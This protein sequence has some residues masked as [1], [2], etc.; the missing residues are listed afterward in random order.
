MGILG[1]IFGWKKKED[2]T[3]AEAKVEPATLE[4]QK[5]V[6]KI[7]GDKELLPHADKGY[8]VLVYGGDFN[9]KEVFPVSKPAKNREVLFN[10]KTYPVVTVDRLVL[11]TY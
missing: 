4:Y 9:G 10:G 11:G 1:N 7:E 5:V 3:K 8:P 6:I 2:S